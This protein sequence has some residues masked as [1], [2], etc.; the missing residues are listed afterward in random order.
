MLEGIYFL[1]EQGFTHITGLLS[2]IQLKDWKMTE[3]SGQG[4]CPL[5]APWSCPRY[6]RVISGFLTIESKLHRK[7]LK[8]LTI[9]ET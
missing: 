3:K 2:Y 7:P 6:E 9:D 5:M 8:S 1:P 4:C